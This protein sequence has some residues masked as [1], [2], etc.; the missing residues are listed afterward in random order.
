MQRLRPMR[1]GLRRRAKHMDRARRWCS[2]VPS[3]VDPA[4]IDKGP[5]DPLRHGPPPS[6]T[7]F[8]KRARRLER[9]FDAGLENIRLEMR[10]GRPRVSCRAARWNR[11]DEWEWGHRL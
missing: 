4:A 6:Q 10:R 7:A 2:D 8:Q 11:A 9:W 5:F 1:M 3:R